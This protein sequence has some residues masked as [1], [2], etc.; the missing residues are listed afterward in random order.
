LIYRIFAISQSKRETFN[1]INVSLKGWEKS[2]KYNVG[3]DKCSLRQK[4]TFPLIVFIMWFF[5][6]VCLVCPAEPHF[7]TLELT[8]YRPNLT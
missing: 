8:Y 1:L 7:F 2:K 4:A 3:A 5:N 6:P